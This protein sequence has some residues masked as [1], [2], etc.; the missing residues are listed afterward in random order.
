MSGELRNNNSG[1]PELDGLAG[2]LS[3]ALRARQRADNDSTDSSDDSDSD[4]DSDSDSDGATAQSPSQR[5]DGVAGALSQAITARLS[6]ATRAQATRA[7]AQQRAHND[8]TESSGDSDDPQPRLA[9]LFAQPD[10]LPP[11]SDTQE[12]PSLGR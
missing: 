6:Q 12:T 10:N 3:R 1:E 9:T 2:A 7:Q 8:S 11:T 4:F 5:L